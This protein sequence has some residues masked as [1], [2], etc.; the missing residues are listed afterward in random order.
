[1]EVSTRFTVF[2]SC[3]RTSVTDV[4]GN[5]TLLFVGKV[6]EFAGTTR[7]VAVARSVEAVTAYAV[8]LVKF[9]RQRVHVGVLRHC[10]VES[11]IEYS[12]LR[13]IGEDL[14]YGIDT[15]E[16]SRIVKRCNIDAFDDFLFYGFVDKYRLVE[17]LSAV[18]DAMTYGVDFFE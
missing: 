11:R 6:Q 17:F 4:A 8:F 18:Y 10:L 14:F 12:D 5:D 3:D 2:D 16:V 13:Y 7:Y 1:M 9:V 15:F